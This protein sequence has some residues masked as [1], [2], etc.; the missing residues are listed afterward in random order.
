MRYHS[1][2]I[3]EEIVVVIS[4]S[5]DLSDP[6]YWRCWRDINLINGSDILYI[7]LIQTLMH[8]LKTSFP[9]KK[10]VIYQYVLMSTCTILI[11]INKWKLIKKA[12]TCENFFNK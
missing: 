4:S 7:Y 2:T 10:E 9:E 11:V 1:S 5:T 12:A 8:V 6:R 3:L